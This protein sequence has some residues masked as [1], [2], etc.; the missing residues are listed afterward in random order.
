MKATLTHLILSLLLSAGMA[1]CTQ[2]EENDQANE[3]R[4]SIEAND[5]ARIADEFERN[6][7][8]RRAQIAEINQKRLHELAS[9]PE[10]RAQMKER[11]LIL[12]HCYVEN[13]HLILK[14]SK[15]EALHL[16]ISAECYDRTLDSFQQTNNHTDSIIALRTESSIYRI[17]HSLMEEAFE[18]ARNGTHEYYKYLTKNHLERPDALAL[19]DRK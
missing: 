11:M 16:G 10:G 15:A 9:T 8:K 2:S 6:W 12:K 14:L 7:E 1:S 3:I 13:E 4:E 17:N 5:R 19:R 18:S